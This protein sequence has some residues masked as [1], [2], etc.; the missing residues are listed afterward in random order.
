MDLDKI[1]FLIASVYF[2][3]LFGGI[4]DTLSCDLK[5]AFDYPLFRHFTAIISIFLLFVIIDKNDNGAYEIWKNTIFLYIFYVLL[6]KNKWY[7]SIPIII[8]VLLDQTILSENKYLEKI[9]SNENNDENNDEN[10][11]TKI[12][13][14]EKYRLYLQYIIIGLIL[15][16]F[17]QY[18]IRQ[19]IK[20][21]NRFNLF[22][23]IFDVK[24]KSDGLNIRNFT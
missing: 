3:L 1:V 16:G 4:G 24:C 7:F 12:E 13:N 23:F 5:K 2:W 20:F 8:L 18:L 11:R 22:T 21:K 19:K 9:M 14:Y 17:I 10:I 6:T 15:I